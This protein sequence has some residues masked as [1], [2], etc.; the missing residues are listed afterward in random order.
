M[1]ITQWAWIVGVILI[2]AG[3]LV[4]NAVRRAA[5]NSRELDV[6]RKAR[7]AEMTRHTIINDEI[8]LD[9]GV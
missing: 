3:S 2:F 4:F 8:D 5:Q 1:T 6:R 7:A 9:S